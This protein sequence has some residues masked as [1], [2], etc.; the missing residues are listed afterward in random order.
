MTHQFCSVVVPNTF[1]RAKYIRSSQPLSP[2]MKSFCNAM[3][4]Q[5][6]IQ[7]HLKRGRILYHLG[8]LDAAINDFRCALR[9]NWRHEEAASWIDRMA[10]EKKNRRLGDAGDQNA[11]ADVTTFLF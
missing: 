8:L 5:V 11:A 3:Y 7:L 9:L 6:R 4:R 1:S 10:Q 2:L